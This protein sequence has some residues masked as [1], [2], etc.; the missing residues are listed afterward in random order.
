MQIDHVEILNLSPLGVL[1]VNA[2]QRVIWCN[3]RFISDTNLP[4]EKVEGQ[5]LAAIPLEAVDKKT[6]L[7]QQF[8][9]SNS[10]SKKFQHWHSPSNMVENATIHYFALK[11]DNNENKPRLNIAKLPKRPNW[12]EFL[13]YEVSRSRRYDNP[14]CVL[15]LHV[16]LNNKPDGLDESDI[17][18]TIKDT[19]M[20]ELRWADMIGNTS[21]GSFL[22]VLPETP[23]SVLEK[24]KNKIL[25]AVEV[26][27]AQLSKSID[28]RIVFGSAYWQ[29]HDDSNR[30]LKRA[31]ENLVT[32]LEESLSQN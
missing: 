22:M 2:E 18:Q 9:E 31:R 24:L 3:S 26:E 27:V 23:N 12:I 7:V 32:A 1:V 17:K 19:I 20:D 6:H 25:K 15:K 29:K 4:R 8:I 13:D 16:L 21:H 14:L 11:R 10:P 5:L 30:L 28:C